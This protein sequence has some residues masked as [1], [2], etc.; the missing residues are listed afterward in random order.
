MI[1]SALELF[2]I[3]FSQASRT[4]DRGRPNTRGGSAAGRAAGRPRGSRSKKDEEEDDDEEDDDDDDEEE[5][6]EE[7][8]DD[9]GWTLDHHHVQERTR[10]AKTFPDLS[11]KGRKK[12]MKLF[13]GTVTKYAPPTDDDHAL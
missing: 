4:S 6:E 11:V 1:L 2:S 13:A 3:S 8:E 12:P 7:D 10:V 9:A 5:E